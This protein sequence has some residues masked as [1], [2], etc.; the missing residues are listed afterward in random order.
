MDQN[1]LIA[2]GHDG[3][4]SLKRRNLYRNQEIMMAKGL[5]TAGTFTGTQEIMMAKG[6]LSV[7]TFTGTRTSWWH[8]VSLPPE[9]VDQNR[10]ITANHDGKGS[11]K[12]RNLYRNQEIMMA[13]GLFSAGTCTGTQEPWWQ[14]VSL[15]PEPVDRNQQ[16][17]A[18]HDGNGSLKR[19]NMYGNQEIMMAKGFFYR[20]NLFIGT[21]EI[22]MAKPLFSAETCRNLLTRTSTGT[23]EIMMAKRLFSA[24][25]FLPEPRKSW[26]QR[27]SS[28]PEPVYTETREIM[29]AK[30]LLSAR[31]FTGT[32]KLWWQSVSLA[33]EPVDRNQEIMMAKG[34]FTAGTFTG[35]QAIM[36]AKGL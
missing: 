2:A 13:K 32:R 28:P 18:N 26:S 31:T 16:F 17:T 3:K 12:R 14:R 19:R 8:R 10:Q 25:P 20:R 34:L 33:P 11:L 22:M 36:L 5:F 35:S 21:Q 23:Q 29:I 15:A 7:G 6:L 1:Q 27:V 4:R 24:G 9:P 30:G